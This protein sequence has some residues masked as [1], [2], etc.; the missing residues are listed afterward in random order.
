MNKINHSLLCITLMLSFTTN[1]IFANE[2]TSKNSKRADQPIEIKVVPWG[3]TE[4]DAEAARRRVEQSAAVQNALKGRKY[5][6]VDFNYI[7]ENV[8]DKS[9]PSRP[10][11]RFRV[12]FYD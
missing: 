6:L 12:F 9:L 1:F 3:P 4:K 8:T 7:E 2:T 10:P 5:R 11:T